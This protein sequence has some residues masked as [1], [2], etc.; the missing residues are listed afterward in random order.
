MKNITVVHP[1]LTSLPLNQW[2]LQDDDP[3][4]GWEVLHEEPTGLTFE[5]SKDY[6]DMRSPS[7]T[8]RRIRRLRITSQRRKAYWYQPVYRSSGRNTPGTSPAGTWWPFEGVCTE[9]M[10]DFLIATAGD[11]PAFFA[12]WL[13]K[14]YFDPANTPE[15]VWKLHR[16]TVDSIPAPLARA[17]GQL[18]ARG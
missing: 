15:P 18:A 3:G 16:K 13:I 5:M 14:G 4:S 11:D 7:G 1:A 8:L 6:F 2:L 17:M 10:A 9:A 12:G